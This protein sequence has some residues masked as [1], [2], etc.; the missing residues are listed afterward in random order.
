MFVVGWGRGEGL[1]RE[2][3]KASPFLPPPTWKL[4]TRYLSHSLVNPTAKLQLGPHS[5]DHCSCV[6]DWPMAMEINREL[7]CPQAAQSGKG[8]LETHSVTY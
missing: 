7:I 8:D 4:G 5:L 1:R 6:L 2:G 3:E